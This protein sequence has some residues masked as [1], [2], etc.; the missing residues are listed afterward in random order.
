MNN[1]KLIMESFNKF[2]N[3]EEGRS[4]QQKTET[5][6]QYIDDL[7]KEIKALEEKIAKASGDKKAKLEKKLADK[8]AQLKKWE[9]GE[10]TPSAEIDGGVIKKK[11]KK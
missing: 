4:S 6:P 8:K 1:M 11:D 2:V 9:S 7:K 3:E 10:M 5:L